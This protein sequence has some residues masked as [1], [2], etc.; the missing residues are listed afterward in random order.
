VAERPH[1]HQ[2]P[3]AR[4]I[5]ELSVDGLLARGEEL[6]RGWALALI[7][8]RPA[9]A[10][11]EVPVEELARE[12]PALCA[13]ALRAVRSDAELERL[14]GRGTPS[15][16]EGAPVARLL[17]EI[18]GARDAVELVDGVEAL[19]GVL[20]EALLD[21][22]RR[23]LFDRS[24]PRL[25]GELGD[26]L[27]H[28]CSAMLAAAIDAAPAHA[29]ARAG[30]GREEPM[31]QGRVVGGHRD[32]V[33]AAASGPVIVDEE[34][35]RVPAPARAS[36]PSPGSSERAPGWEAP[37]RTRERPVTEAIRA[38]GAEIEIHDRREEPHGPRRDEGPAAWTRSISAQL[39][40][41]ERDGLP[42][43]VLL[44]ELLELER[45]RREEPPEELSSLAAR[46]EDV[47]G[48]ALEATG[49][50]TRERPGRCWLVAP[51]LDRAGAERLARRLADA[52]SYSAG[53]SRSALYVAIGTAVCPENGRQAAALAAHADLGLYAARA[54]ARAGF[55]A[56]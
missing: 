29:G 23:P 46:M 34:R 24:V 38:A 49:S 26:R 30:V 8:S 14:V 6:A 16:R 47:L 41:F 32:E 19:R 48:D 56:R 9:A 2:T 18:C 35:A 5:A 54:A 20:W 45:L 7:I 13:Q 21:D 52:A 31:A 40:R 11:G 10:I 28:V 39:A 22:L 12:A 1:P 17:W 37:A 36:V 4:P 42:F 43:A 3:R 15:A 33:A 27:A 55:S 25:L 44:V 53:R 51:R 50:L